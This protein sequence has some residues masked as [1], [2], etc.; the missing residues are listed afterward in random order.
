MNSHDPISKVD[1]ATGTIPSS[2]ESGRLH[3][4]VSP[5]AMPP[6]ARLLGLALSAGIL[7]GLA[8]W[9]IGEEVRTAF[10]PPYQ[11]QNVMGQVIMKATFQDQSAA[12]L[13]N[14]TLAF[15]ILGGMLGLA[16]GLAGG[17]A[18]RSGR[19]G[20]K[21]AAVGLVLG[22]VTAAGASHGTLADLFPRARPGPGG[23]VA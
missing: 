8:S 2:D 16:L 21:A 1:A 12:D 14:A 7:A 17:I 4:A 22:S 23:N 9:L 3:E 18:C 13:K 6:A 20:M 10:R 5:A 15:G 11:P 19:A